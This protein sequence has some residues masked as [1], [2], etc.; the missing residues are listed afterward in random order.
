MK[1]NK[2]IIKI[3]GVP[4]SN[5]SFNYFKEKFINEDYLFF[6]EL[7]QT[8]KSGFKIKIGNTHKKID[9]SLYDKRNFNIDKS[10]TII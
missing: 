4:K 3:K 5:I 8:R 7:F 6:N 1:N 9:L 2:S 10:D